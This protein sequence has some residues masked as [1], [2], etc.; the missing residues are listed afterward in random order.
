VSGTFTKDTAMEQTRTSSI[1]KDKNA[2]ELVE[3]ANVARYIEDC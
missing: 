2:R 3:G 1:E